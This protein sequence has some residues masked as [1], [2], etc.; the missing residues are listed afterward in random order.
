MRSVG[1]TR[2]SLHFYIPTDCTD[3][4]W[5]YLLSVLSVVI[6]EIRRIHKIKFTLFYIPRDCTD[7]HWYYLLSV[8]SVVIREISGINKIKFHFF[9]FP[10]IALIGTDIICYPCYPWDPWEWKTKGNHEK[11]TIVFSSQSVRIRLRIACM[12]VLLPANGWDPPLAID[13]FWRDIDL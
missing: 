8:L 6:R 12:W 3:W 7:W 5:Y 4:H 11:S 10:R 2:I 9:T 1:I 13:S